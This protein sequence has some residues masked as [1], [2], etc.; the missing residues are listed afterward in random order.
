MLITEIDERLNRG[1]TLRFDSKYAQQ[2]MEQAAAHLDGEAR[3]WQMD[4]GPRVVTITN[5]RVSPA[6]DR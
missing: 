1:E 4:I 3:C 2:I 5:P 6:T